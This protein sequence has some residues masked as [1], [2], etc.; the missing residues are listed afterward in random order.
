[1]KNSPNIQT[2]AEIPGKLKSIIGMILTLIFLSSCAQLKL[3]SGASFN[4]YPKREVS[5]DAVLPK[6]DTKIVEECF[7]TETKVCR[8]KIISAGML[9]IDINFSKFEENLFREKREISFLATL[10]TLGLNAAGT[11]T[12]T[13]ILSAISG[14]IIG[15]KSAYDSE[16]LLEKSVLAIHTQMRAQRDEI[17]TRLRGGLQAEIED[18]HLAEAIIDL[19]SYYSAG[20]LLSAF[21]SMTESAGV[22]AE[23]AKEELKDVVNLRISK[24]MKTPAGDLIRKFWKPDGNTINKDNELKIKNWFE[25]NNLKGEGITYF[26]RAK[27]YEIKRLEMVNDLGLR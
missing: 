4:G 3:P 25:N 1:M 27:E 21:V 18:Y 6:I 22:K 5:T 12:G 26:S 13:S 11:M 24:Y 8:N 9:V 19:E 14:G 16:I 7:E 15:A 2:L 20:T 23:K 17:A 10:A